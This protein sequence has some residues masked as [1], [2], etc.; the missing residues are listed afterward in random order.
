MFLVRPKVQPIRL[1]LG[2]TI[3]TCA[4]SCWRSCIAI[5][6]SMGLLLHQSEA[7]GNFP[8]NLGNIAAAPMGVHRTAPPK[9]TAQIWAAQHW[10]KRPGIAMRRGWRN[11]LEQL[12]LLSGWHKCLTFV[13]PGVLWDRTLSI[14]VWQRRI[15]G[16]VFQKFQPIRSKPSANKTLIWKLAMFILTG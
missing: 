14:Q 16:G 4:E 8:L 5:S 12:F 2:S 1:L 15:S 13:P 6:T 11:S 7:K 9:L 10:C 3:L